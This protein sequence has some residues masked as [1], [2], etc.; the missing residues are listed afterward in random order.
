MAFFKQ[1]IYCPVC[2]KDSLL[3]S[4]HNDEYFDARCA[5]CRV[6]YFYKPGL[7][8]PYKNLTDKEK[9]KI[10]GYCGPGGCICRS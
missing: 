8:V 5:E 3:G 6:T 1:P 2:R 10:K 7:D 9:D 4:R